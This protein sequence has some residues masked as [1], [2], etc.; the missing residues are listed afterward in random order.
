MLNCVNFH[1]NTYNMFV[2]YS[3]ICFG[4]CKFI[5]TIYRFIYLFIIIYALI[6]RILPSKEPIAYCTTT[7]NEFKTISPISTYAIYIRVLY[8]YR[9]R[10]GCHRAVSI[11]R[12]TMIHKCY[13]TSITHSI[14]DTQ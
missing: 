12:S 9:Y 1:L 14:I 5:L 13:S 7:E 8:L 10:L 4:I 3:Y 2:V 6:V 11:A